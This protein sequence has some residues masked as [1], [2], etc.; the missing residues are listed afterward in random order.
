MSL[1]NCFWGHS[2]Y[3]TKQSETSKYLLQRTNSVL[4]GSMKPDVLYAMTSSS[5][6]RRHHQHSVNNSKYSLQRNQRD[7]YIS[8]SCEGSST[9]RD[10]NDSESVI[11]A[12]T[13]PR[14]TNKCR[15]ELFTSP[16][17]LS[18]RTVIRFSYFR[19]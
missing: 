7:I 17:S 5:V 18:P 2:V 1:V 10:N 16:T 8:A 4:C 13:A 15:R 6:Y 12:L 3:T 9:S 14:I 19:V 11:T